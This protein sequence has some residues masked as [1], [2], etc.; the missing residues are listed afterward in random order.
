MSDQGI[1]RPKQ[2]TAYIGI[3]FR[4]ETAEAIK[5]IAEKR[6]YFNETDCFGKKLAHPKFGLAT[7]IRDIIEE[8]VK[9]HP[10]P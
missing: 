3:Y 9:N 5:R 8:Y 7:T 10:I 1:Q 6:G 2:Y 4:P